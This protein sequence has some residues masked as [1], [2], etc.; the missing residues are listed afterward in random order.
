MNFHFSIQRKHN[1]I[2]IR[3]SESDLLAKYLYAFN[4]LDSGIVYKYSI[5]YIV[6]I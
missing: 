6:S 5:V 3:T 1:T 4:K 2:F